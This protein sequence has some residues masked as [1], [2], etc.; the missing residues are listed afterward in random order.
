MDKSKIKVGMT[1]ET[2]MSYDWGHAKVLCLGNSQAF[3]NY[4]H[5][6]SWVNSGGYEDA[7]L[8]ENINDIVEE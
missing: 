3:V 5:C 4:P 6:P 1:V 8:Y 2:H 7:V